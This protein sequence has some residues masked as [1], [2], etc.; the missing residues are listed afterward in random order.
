VVKKPKNQLKNWAVFSGIGIQ[1]GLTIFLG[2]L[3][4]VWL[5]KKLST[6]FLEETITLI[7]VFMAMYIVIKRVNKF[8]EK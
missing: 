2:N 4:G 7:A 8:D 3:I 6:S 5:D 1:M